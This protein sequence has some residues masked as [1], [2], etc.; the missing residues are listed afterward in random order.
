LHTLSL[1]HSW[2]VPVPPIEEPRKSA[3]QEMTGPT[4]GVDHLEAFE[5]A[6]VKRRLQ[7]PE[8]PPIPRCPAD[9]RL[10]TTWLW[11]DPNCRWM[12]MATFIAPK[13]RESIGIR[14]S[15]NGMARP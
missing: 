11:E 6:L 7:R 1:V 2:C 10:S 12:A 9:F 3:Q 15:R 13:I 14:S 8:S 4:G 5:R